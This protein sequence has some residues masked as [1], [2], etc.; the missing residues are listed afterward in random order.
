MPEA[1]L[2]NITNLGD[3]EVSML[4]KRDTV[5]VTGGANDINEN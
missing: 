4:G 5:I 3:E 1:R 2:E